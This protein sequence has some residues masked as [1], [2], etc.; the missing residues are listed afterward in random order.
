MSLPV[1][2]LAENSPFV[3]QIK[4]YLQKNKKDGVVE[5]L[6]KFKGK[7]ATDLQLPKTNLKNKFPLL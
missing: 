5:F 2:P 6:V 1:S 3:K 7:L 4:V